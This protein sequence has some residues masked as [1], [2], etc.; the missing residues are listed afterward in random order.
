M[1][2]G[3]VYAVI[4]SGDYI[5]IGGQFTR[6]RSVPPGT[7]G[8]GYA[9]FG[10]ARINAATGVGDKTWTPDVTRTDGKRAIV[11]ALAA[12]GGKI[13]IGGTF[14]RVDGQPRLNFAAASESTG[15]LDPNVTARVGPELGKNVLAMVASS[16]TVFIGGRFN[17]V[18]GT[19]RKRLAAFDVGT[20]NLRTDWKPQT[21][22]LVRTMAFDCTGATVLAGGNFDKAKGSSGTAQPR[23]RVARFDAA[24]GALHAW[25]IPVGALTNGLVTYDLGLH[26]GTKKLFVGFGGQNYLYA[27]D[28]GDD[29]GDVLWARQS[30]GNVQTVAVRGDRVLFGGHFSQVTYP[31]GTCS[32][33]KP[34]LTRFA[35]IDLNGNCDLGWRPSF[36]G[37]FYGPW[38]ILVTDAGSR[39]WVG[40][41][42][43][44][45]SKTPQYFLA[46]F[47]DD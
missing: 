47:T 46:R 13:W 4:R 5:Y 18:D 37:K 33:T 21:A 35:V 32:E 1:T 17:D 26:C 29:V 12:A 28:F 10:V 27:I 20:G 36:D 34:K 25:A 9:A 42:F 19:P 3:T 41:Q 14:D 45:V 22:G 15:A 43:T 23:P 8:T 7:K 2:N 39:I 40:G 38:D 31:T 30:A 16:S 6:V 11:Y 24:T 44:E